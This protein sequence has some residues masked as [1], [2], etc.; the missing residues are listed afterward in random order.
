MQDILSLQSVSVRSFHNTVF[1]KSHVIAV[2]NFTASIQEKAAKDNC[3]QA[4]HFEES[5]DRSHMKTNDKLSYAVAC[6]APATIN[7]GTATYITASV[8]SGTCGN[9]APR[10]EPSLRAKH[11]T[12]PPILPGYDPSSEM[13]SK[14]HTISPGE[15]NP[16]TYPAAS[17]PW[18]LFQISVPSISERGNNHWAIVKSS[19]ANAL[20]C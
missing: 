6:P 14:S 13:G 10:T 7:M 12:T 5:D 9:P 2:A 1:R 4:M 20:T 11:V 18:T 15:E 16:L 3:H 17:H 8:A 19:D